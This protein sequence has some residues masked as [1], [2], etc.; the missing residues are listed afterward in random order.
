MLEFFKFIFF[1]AF[2]ITVKITQSRV[3]ANHYNNFITTTLKT[4]M[5]AMI[6]SAF[7]YIYYVWNDY[8]VIF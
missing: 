7:L 3:I 2:L 4:F 1:F 8:K 5:W 6:P